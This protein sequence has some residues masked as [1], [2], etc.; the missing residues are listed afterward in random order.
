MNIVEEIS[1]RKKE[2]LFRTRHILGSVQGPLIRIDGEEYLN[3]SSNDYLGLANNETLKACMIDAINTYGIG[4]GS[5]QLVVGHSTAHHLL[6]KK[7][8]EFLNREAAL[9]FS[10][11][12]HANLAV[13]SALINSN[14]VVLQDKLNHASLIDAA[15]L[16]RGKLVRY[17]HKDMKQLE[18]LLEKYNNMIC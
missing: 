9:V 7:L 18:S 16:S 1:Q 2:D 14:T 15:I 3:F 10:T 8:S 11:G 4:A 12:Y 13:A 17:R 5:S 6:E